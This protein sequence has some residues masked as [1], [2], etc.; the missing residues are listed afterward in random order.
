MLNQNQLDMPSPQPI[1]S[2]VVQIFFLTPL[3]FANSA[4]GQDPR[5]FIAKTTNFHMR[6]FIMFKDPPWGISNL[7]S[8][9]DSDT[10]RHV[11]SDHVNLHIGDDHSARTRFIQEMDQD[12]Q[13]LPPIFMKSTVRFVQYIP[14]DRDYDDK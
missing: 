2:H 6:K 8:Y 1:I 10:A 12:R 7:D 5:F 4:I 14:S 3:S 11:T 9:L 13:L